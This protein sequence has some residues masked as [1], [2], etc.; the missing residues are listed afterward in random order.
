LLRQVYDP[1]IIPA[2]VA[3]LNLALRARSR[4]AIL[5]LTVR[6]ADTLATFLRHAGTVDA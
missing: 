3:T 4:A 1:A 6:N 2:L 5:A